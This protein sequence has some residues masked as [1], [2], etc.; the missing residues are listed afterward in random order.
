MRSHL[1][2]QFDLN[3][4]KHYVA[5]ICYSVG[6]GGEML[7][8]EVVEG[9]LGVSKKLQH[10]ILRLNFILTHFQF[11]VYEC[12]VREPERGQ[13]LKYRLRRSLIVF[14]KVNLPIDYIHRKHCVLQE[15]LYFRLGFALS[16]TTIFDTQ[17]LNRLLFSIV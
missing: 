8:S 6:Q 10:I 1:S 11:P 13:F 12:I 5:I 7:L 9:V 15:S 14:G 17:I 3:T 4:V 2:R 16:T